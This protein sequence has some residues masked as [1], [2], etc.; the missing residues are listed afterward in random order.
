MGGGICGRR[1]GGE[2]GGSGVVSIQ[3]TRDREGGIEPGTDFFP[4]KK[5]SKEGEYFPLAGPGKST[6]QDTGPTKI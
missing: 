3:G 1:G 2:G 5:R 6:I 4:R